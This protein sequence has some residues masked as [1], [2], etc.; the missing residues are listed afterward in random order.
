MYIDREIFPCE[1][2]KSDEQLFGI[3]D[4]PVYQSLCASLSVIHILV[5]HSC[6]HLKKN[7]P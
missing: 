1:V 6:I 4:M 3:L 7:K 5:F 2:G